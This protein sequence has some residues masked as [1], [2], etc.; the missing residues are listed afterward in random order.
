MRALVDLPEADIRSLDA[1]AKAKS[2]SRAK[3]IR[4]AIVVYL[5]ASSVDPIDASFGAWR[6]EPI[7]GV[8]FQRAL[9]DEW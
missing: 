4:E 7:D 5:S 8:A 1:L 2:T 3:L 6:D 9:R